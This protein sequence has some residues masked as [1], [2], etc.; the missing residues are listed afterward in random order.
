[1]AKAY[2][3]EVK[4]FTL[5]WEDICSKQVTLLKERSFKTGGK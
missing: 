2:D 4:T 5:S 3:P 1:M